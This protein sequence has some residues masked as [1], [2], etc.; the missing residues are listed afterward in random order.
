MGELKLEYPDESPCFHCG[1]EMALKVNVCPSCNKEVPTRLTVGDLLVGFTSAWMI[2]V[3]LGGLVVGREGPETDIAMYR[4]VV[5]SIIQLSGF[6]QGGQFIVN[7][8]A[9]IENT[10]RLEEINSDVDS[11]AAVLH[12]VELLPRTR[13][14][15]TNG[16]GGPETNLSV[17]FQGG[18][19]VVN[20]FATKQHFTE[21]QEINDSLAP[22]L[23]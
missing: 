10:E 12:H 6:M 4:A 7:A 23:G 16:P 13:V 2:D 21:L 20:R 11:E 1:K 14:F 5:P 18:Q 22:K 15:N 19:F 3:R 8:H 17:L 9:A